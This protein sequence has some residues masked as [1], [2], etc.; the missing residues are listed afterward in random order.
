MS[1]FKIWVI[2]GIG[3]VI[4]RDS[5]SFFAKQIGLANFFIWNVAAD[6]FIKAS[7][8]KSFWGNILGIATDL[9]IGGM[10]GVAFGLFLNFTGNKDYLLKG[11]GAGLFTWLFFFG[12]VFHNLPQTATAAPK[13]ALSSLS[14]IVGH[15]IFGLSMAFIYGRLITD[16]ISLK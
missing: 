5:Y 2:S 6:I 11:V 14:A 15:T 12:L 4:I 7:E 3:G 16:K 1:K 8:L 10:I 9:I 13:D